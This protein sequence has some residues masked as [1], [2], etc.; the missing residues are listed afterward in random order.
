MSF[1][2]IAVFLV[3]LQNTCNKATD[4][5]TIHFHSVQ[6]SG[7]VVDEDSRECGCSQRVRMVSCRCLQRIY[8]VDG[9]G[10]TVQQETQMFYDI[11]IS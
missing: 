9:D 2:S 4:S 1:L 3:S 10:L 6:M 7:L 11:V 5:T 8:S